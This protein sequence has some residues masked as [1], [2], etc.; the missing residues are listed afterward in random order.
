MSD[1]KKPMSGSSDPTD[2]PS[3]D[4]LHLTPWTPDDDYVQEYYRGHLVE[5]TDMTRFYATKRKTGDMGP[6]VAFLGEAFSGHSSS[7]G[8][9]ISFDNKAVASA[10]GA[11]IPN[12]DRDDDGDEDDDDGEDGDDDDDE[13]TASDLDRLRISISQAREADLAKL[14]EDWNAKI[15][16]CRCE[17]TVDVHDMKVNNGTWL[18]TKL[19]DNDAVLDL[20]G[21]DFK[22]VTIHDLKK[23][24]A[25]C[26]DVLKLMERHHHRMQMS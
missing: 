26:D 2:G 5:T 4:I 21:G 17:N 12:D 20:Y 6:A 14:V 18:V 9:E 24:F 10:T 3:I 25:Q 1:T 13:E 16:K 8:V 11:P 15:Q 22:R 19:G 7:G 23:F